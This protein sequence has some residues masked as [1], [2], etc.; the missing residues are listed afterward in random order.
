MTEKIDEIRNLKTHYTNNLYDVTRKEQIVDQ[1]YR[2]DT[3]TVDEV[4]GPHTI[5]RSGIGTRMVDAPAEQIVTSNPQVFVEVLKGSQ[6]A[7]E[8]ISKLINKTWIP[9]IRRQSPNPFKESVKNKLCRG[10]SYIYVCH[11]ESWVTGDKIKEGLPVFFLIP[12]PMVIYGSP[13]EDENGVPEKVVI[14]YER[15]YRD[16]IVRYP[17]W[18][19]PE[20]RD[21]QNGK[22]EWFEY[23][24]TG[25]KY[26]EAD[27]E[28]VLPE[29]GQKNIYGFVPFGRKRSGF[30]RRSPDGELADLIVS[31]LRMS[32]D[33][34]KEECIA[35]S[36][37]A[38]VEHIFAHKPR[39]I[40]SP[41]DI[42]EEQVKN[43]EWGAYT[44]NVLSNVVEGTTLE[45]DKTGLPTPDMYT[46]LQSIKSDL[47]QRNPFLVSGA[48][49]GSSGR[50]QM[51]AYT[52]A[53]RRYDTV[54]E[55]TE[56]EWAT[57]FEMALKICKAV[58]T[59]MPEG[60]H[61]ADLDVT[62][63][64]SVKLKASDPIE[65]DRLA[66]LGDRL[67]AQGSGSIDLKTNLVQ[68][69]GKTGDE[70]EEIIVNL[71]VDKVTLQNPDVAQVMGMMFAEEAGMAKYLQEA[72]AR[73]MQM[74]QQ[75]KGLQDAPPKTTTE[76]VKGETKTPLGNEM[77]DMAL[78]NKGAR[79]SPSR[80]TRGQ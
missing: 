18:G 7:G 63:R 54:I 41:G 27:G 78:S 28:A 1:A 22:V 69:Q 48:P 42:N 13:E 52:T 57:A 58:P 39:T 71:L 61:K 33:L 25:F 59:L 2:D 74:E 12:D 53:M 15:Q 5:Y 24:D 68:Y 14:F 26:F 16:V 20:N 19:N 38:S 31:D 55:N 77:M 30:G 49:Q 35:R 10:E 40:I 17:N 62:I 46:H 65:E 45:E 21:T 3:F 29:D 66:T 8:R 64:L 67:W 44:L 51:D 9:I 60:L 50:Q 23:W 70:A 75:Q 73:A 79:Q 32:R 43:F 6:D 72:Q 36:N 56:N 11:N 47:V 37:I 34:I 80:F 4:K 76:R